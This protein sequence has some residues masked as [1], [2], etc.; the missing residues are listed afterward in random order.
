MNIMKTNMLMLDNKFMKEDAGNTSSPAPAPSTDKP[1]E[2]MKALSFMGMKNLMADPKLAKEVGVMNNSSAPHSSNITFQG[3]LS[4]GKKFAQML[5]AG[6]IALSTLILP[7]CE[8]DIKMSQYQ[9]VNV[10]LEAVVDAIN[11]LREEI[12]AISNA[13]TDRDKEMLQ[14]LNN[15]L[16]VLYKIQTEVKNQ[17]LSIEEFKTLVLGKMDNGELQRSAILEAIMK[18]QNITEDAAVSVVTSILTAYENGRID[19]QTAMA[20][21]QELLKE[22]NSLLKSI[23]SSL[24]D[25]KDKAGAYAK[26]LLQLVKDIKAKGDETKEQQNYI[27]NQNKTLIEQNNIQITQGE[28]LIEEVKKVNLSVQDLEV[29]AKTIGKSIEEVMKMSKDEIIAAIKGNVLDLKETN[30]KLDN[31][32][33][34]IKNNT[35]TIIDVAKD[36]EDILNKIAGDVSDI[37]AMLKDHFTK[38]DTDMAELKALMKDRNADIKKIAS[39]MAQVSAD[40][41]TLN[42]DV[43]K[44]KVDIENGIELTFDDSE[45]KEIL[46]KINVTQEMSKTEVIAKMDEFITKQEG[47]AADLTETNNL[48]T[49]LGN[50]VSKDV[51]N[52]INNIGVDLDG[53][54]DINNKLDELLAAVK[55]LATSFDLHA[56]FV[57]NAHGEEMEAL[58]GIKSEF[59]TV[60]DK[61][62]ILIGQGADADKKRDVIIDFVKGIDVL[63]EQGK[64]ADKKRDIMIEYLKGLQDQA[65][66]ITV[67]LGR[68][69][70][71]DEFDIMLNKHDANNQKYYGD[72]IKAAGVDP[73]EFENIKDLLKTINENLVDFQGTSNGYLADILARIKAMDPTAPDYTEKLNKIIDLM[74]NFKFECNCKCDCDHNQAVDEGIIDIIG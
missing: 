49:K 48:I 34:S 44:I 18:L 9:E 5:P 32:N 12:K 41:Q 6:L 19:F 66:S 11:A 16:N 4:A 62:D 17:T 28:K 3:K 37:K 14:A 58:G 68:I 21:I 51:I 20:K 26:E 73:A 60:D 55:A 47:M 63:I 7:S 42:N 10:D 56:K 53:I 50:V 46:K 67:K 29:V 64:T 38:Y 13:Q 31:I 35:A 27:I 74:E 43:K 69:P 52:A 23:L 1:Q 30:E 65:D 54:K 40:I 2:G 25:A 45:L 71:V 24:N 61:L 15:A 57:V 59:K 8:R 39:Y 72:L 70:T 22:N 33:N 36:Y